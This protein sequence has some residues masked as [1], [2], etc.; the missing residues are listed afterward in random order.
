MTIGALGVLGG[1]QKYPVK[2]YQA[3]NTVEKVGPLLEQINW[4][5]QWGASHLFWGGIHCYSLSK[6]CDPAWLD[7]V[8][9]WLDNNLDGTPPREA[10]WA[11]P[12]KQGYG[13][14]SLL[15][16]GRVTAYIARQNSSE[17]MQVMA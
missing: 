9:G 2:L 15:T 10:P 1:R 16:W 5:K 12:W 3:F 17:I 6:T 4:A 14:S 11:T 8:F 7:Y 13:S